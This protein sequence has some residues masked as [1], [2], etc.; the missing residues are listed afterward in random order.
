MPRAKF[1]AIGIVL[2]GVIALAGGGTLLFLR[3]HHTIALGFL[4][5]GLVVA[6]AGVGLAIW[7]RTSGV[8]HGPGGS[9][10]FG[11]TRRTS[12]RTL[13]TLIAGLII[14]GATVGSYVYVSS[15][16]SAHSGSKL[17]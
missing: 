14:G 5:I 2:I 7:T 9:S 1:L 4:A 6:L 17:G 13:Q 10:E 3:L 11:S 15:Q 12:S 16:L 8:S